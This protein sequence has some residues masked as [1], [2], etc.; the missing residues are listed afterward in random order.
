MHYLILLKLLHDYELG[1]CATVVGCHL[2]CV[3]QDRGILGIGKISCC[4][5][6]L[7]LAL[8]SPIV[9]HNRVDNVAGSLLCLK[10]LFMAFLRR[11]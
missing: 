3:R 11:T 6:C 1:T 9:A 8:I 4:P 2:S 10:V 7:C 5:L